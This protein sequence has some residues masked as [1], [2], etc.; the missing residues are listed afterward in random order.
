MKAGNAIKPIA[1]MV[2]IQ[3]LRKAA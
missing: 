3:S 2:G 1:T